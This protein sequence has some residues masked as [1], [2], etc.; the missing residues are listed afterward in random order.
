MATK[1]DKLR[2]K[3]T[4]VTLG[5]EPYLATCQRCGG[6]ADRPQLPMKL[7]SFVGVLDGVLATH[8]HCVE[9]SK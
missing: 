3:V 4:W 6:H 2:S 9:R 5:P 8:E 1:Q 7:D